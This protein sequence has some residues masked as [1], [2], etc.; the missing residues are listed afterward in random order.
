MIEPVGIP[1]DCG[2]AKVGPEGDSY[3]LE[4]FMVYEDGPRHVAVSGSADLL[5]LALGILKY[6]QDVADEDT[7]TEGNDPDDTPDDIPT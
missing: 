7:T 3:S 6:L 1:L 2:V 5:R 4:L